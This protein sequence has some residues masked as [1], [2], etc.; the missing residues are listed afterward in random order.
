MTLSDES[1]IE[2][3]QK[4]DLLEQEIGKHGGSSHLFE[5]MDEMREIITP[6]TDYRVTLVLRLHP[7][8]DDPVGWNWEEILQLHP[9]SELL[10]LDVSGAL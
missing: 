7:D 1:A 6:T 4:L 9:Q 8:D 5:T 2:L 10:V 3:L